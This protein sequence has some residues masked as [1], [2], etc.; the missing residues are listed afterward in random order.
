ML[1]KEN[2]STAKALMILFSFAYSKELAKAFGIS[3]IAP[4][5]VIQTSKLLKLF[6]KVN[7]SN[8]G[9]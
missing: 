8:S 6:L 3:W 5:D 4:K 1:L 2:N 7:S 9:I